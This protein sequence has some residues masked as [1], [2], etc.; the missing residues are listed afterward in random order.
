MFEEAFDGLKKEN[1]KVMKENID[2]RE[3]DKYLSIIMSDLSVKLKDQDQEIKSLTIAIKLLLQ[4][5]NKQSQPEDRQTA[6]WH[7]I[8]SSE[9]KSRAA[10]AYQLPQKGVE[11]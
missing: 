4:H 5:D 10:P 11:K 2:L 9:F 8:P 6:P 7:T 1:L 3:G